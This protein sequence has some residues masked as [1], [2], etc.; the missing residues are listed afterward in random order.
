MLNFIKQKIASLITVLFAAVVF[1]LVVFMGIRSGR[2]KAYSEMIYENTLALEDA[3]NLFYNDQDRYPSVQEFSKNG[4]LAKYINKQLWVEQ[5][6]ANR[7][8]FSDFK[9][10]LNRRSSY[11]LSFCLPQK[12]KDF[13]RGWNQINAK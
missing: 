5:V 11:T 9:Y 4:N 2:E 12:L 3:L 13:K 6:A 10:V 7:F 8:C 1:I